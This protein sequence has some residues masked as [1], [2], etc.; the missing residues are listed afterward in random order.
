MATSRNP[1]CSKRLMISPTSPRWTPSGLMAMKRLMIS[2]T[3]PLWTPSGLM[4][5]KVR[6]LMAA[7]ILRRERI[8]F[9]IPGLCNPSPSQPCLL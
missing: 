5:M 1:F 4:A 3:S 7:M 8:K 9:V 6:S 2:P